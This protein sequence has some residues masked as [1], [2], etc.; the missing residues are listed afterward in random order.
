M[1]VRNK[2]NLTQTKIIDD[3]LQQQQQQQK[4]GKK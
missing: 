4:Q 2:D 1:L 3:N